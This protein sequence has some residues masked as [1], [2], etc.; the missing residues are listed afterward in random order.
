MHSAGAYN[1]RCMHAGVRDA[2]EPA[3]QDLRHRLDRGRQVLQS[4]EVASDVLPA[5]VMTARARVIRGREMERIVTIRCRGA[6]PDGRV[7]TTAC[8]HGTDALGWQSFIPSEEFTIL[9]REDIVGDDAE[10]TPLAQRPAERE[11]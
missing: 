2:A 9:A 6:L 1:T 8:F 11:R 10:R 4:V 5:D 7:R 3:H